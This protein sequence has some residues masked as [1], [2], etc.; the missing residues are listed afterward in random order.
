MSG[1]EMVLTLLDKFVVRDRGAQVSLELRQKQPYKQ[2]NTH[3]P[4]I[5]V[6]SGVGLGPTCAT[7]C[8]PGKCTEQQSSDTGGVCPR[9]VAESQPPPASTRPVHRP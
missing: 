2:D 1:L 3:K 7:A 4:T 8:F 5:Y 9:P 6:P